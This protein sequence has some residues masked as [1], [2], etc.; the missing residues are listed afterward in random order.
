MSSSQIV[1]GSKVLQLGRRIG[2][3]GEGEVFAIEGNDT[4]AAKLYTANDRSARESKV[5]AMVRASLAK[6]A[7]LA[8]FPMAMARRGDGEFV[9]FIMR[10]VQGHKPLHEIYSPGSRKIHF[11]QADY[12]FLVRVATNIARSIASVHRAGCV[13]G[14]INHSSMLVS[15]NAVVALIDADSFQILDG[16]KPYLCRV[17]VPEYT[18]PEL[19]GKA[20]SGVVRTTNHDAF[21]LAVVIFQLLFMGRHPFVGT[22]RNAMEMPPLYENIQRY[23]YVYADDRDVGMDQ[24]P[25]TPSLSDFSPSLSGRFHAAFLNR[26]ENGRPSAEEWI[27]HLEELEGSLVQCA[28]NPL[29]YGP[30]GASACAWCEMERRLNVVLFLPYYPMPHGV[31]VPRDTEAHLF[32]IN[33][34]WARIEA[35]SQPIRD[36]FQP[37]LPRL[38][39]APSEAAKRE[40]GKNLWRKPAGLVVLAVALAAL[41]YAPA[42]FV[43]YVPLAFW[44]M[45][46]MRHSPAS[47]ESFVRAYVAAEQSWA[48]EHDGWHGRL[49][50]DEIDRIRGELRAARDTYAHAGE[51]ERSSIAKYRTERRDRQLHS[52]LDRFDI[53]STKIKG[54]GPAKLA[55]LAS[56]GID[57]AADVELSKL[58]SVP[59]FGE[60]NSKGLLEWRTKLERRFAYSA[61]END[62]DRQAIARI[63]L[64]CQTKASKAR[65]T[66]QAGVLRLE[67]LARR[68]KDIASRED[69]VLCRMHLLREQAKVDLAHLGIALPT[70]AIPAF[71]RRSSAAPASGSGPSQ[72]T[73]ASGSAQPSCPRCG[74][75]MQQRLARRGRNAGNYFWGCKRYPACKGTRSI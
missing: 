18:P 59:G 68:V 29:H 41:L 63:R 55:A 75:S 66:L 11:P 20:F 31:D 40:K 10:L 9:G 5:D 33:A 62:A 57:T 44:G 64:A 14:D 53:A 34:V 38:Q 48:R 28:D 3:G 60:T 30:K 35:V 22:P 42:L 72:S 1:V 32:D 70:L 16:G 45:S 54:V 52:F 47:A 13:V 61:H 67:G 23:R 71:N 43:V 8:A 39:L 46:I 69:P 25:G 37:A 56:Y 73:M 7:P 58:L 26:D 12:R 36:Q 6:H 17:G 74:S 24:P 2:K 19:Q 65:G 15:P 49:G 4:L 50:F 51:E 27:A 21:G